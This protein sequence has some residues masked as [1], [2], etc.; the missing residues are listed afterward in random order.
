MKTLAFILLL[1]FAYDVCAQDSLFVRVYDLHGK[2]THKGRIASITDS[3]LTLKLQNALTTIPVN[4]IGTI[5]TRRSAGHNFLVGAL[6]GIV[7]GALLGIAASHSDDDSFI[8]FSTGDWAIGGAAL[9]MLIGGP[10]GAIAS[11]HSIRFP[12]DGDTQKWKY[13]QSGIGR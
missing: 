7:P 1:S 4:Q 12:I 13:F 9:G 6:I 5:R 3:T 2:K 8:D 11:K 10:V